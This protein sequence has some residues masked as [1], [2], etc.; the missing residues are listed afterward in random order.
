MMR[1]RK[2]GDDL[3]SSGGYFDS[4]LKLVDDLWAVTLASPA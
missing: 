1:K 2:R 3:F 4:R